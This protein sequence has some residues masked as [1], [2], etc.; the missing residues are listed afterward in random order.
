MG[1][2]GRVDLDFGSD[3]RGHSRRMSWV[4]WE[5]LLLPPLTRGTSMLPVCLRRLE[6]ASRQIPDLLPSLKTPQVPRGP[7]GWWWAWNQEPPAFSAQASP[8]CVFSPARGVLYALC[9]PHPHQALD[10][11][12]NTRRQ[13]R[14][15]LRPESPSRC[16]SS[17]PRLL[18]SSGFGQAEALSPAP[19]TAV[20]SGT[21]SPSTHSAPV[22]PEGL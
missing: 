3:G 14:L 6:S 5:W 20:S 21:T 22:A 7:R 1:K 15:G 12:Q 16:S 18:I 9:A 10:P 4:W 17:A 19:F 8:T 2:A 13:H 11:S